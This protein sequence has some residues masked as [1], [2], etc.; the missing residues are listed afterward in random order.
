MNNLIYEK[1][2]NNI[3]IRVFL[4]ILIP[5]ALA[6]GALFLYRYGNP[7]PCLIYKFFNIYCPGCGSGRA[8]SFMLHWDFI[9]AL[10]CN[11]FVV[12]IFP[13]LLYYFFT[14]YIK[15]LFN[16]SL[17]SPKLNNSVFYCFLIIM[18]AFWTLRNIRSF[19][20]YLLA[21]VE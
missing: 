9:K 21:P 17:P 18:I 2:R 15:F 5:S 7:A 12:I 19:P 20:F 13:F 1:L 10:R 8:L 16:I 6:L 4:G 14:L 3:F 11:P